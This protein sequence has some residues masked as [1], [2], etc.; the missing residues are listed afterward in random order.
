LRRRQFRCH[1]AKHPFAFN[2]VLC[3]TYGVTVHLG[4]IVAE[5]GIV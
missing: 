4:E 3:T 5:S 1:D 2:Y